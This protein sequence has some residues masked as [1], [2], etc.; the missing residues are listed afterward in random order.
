MQSAV[1]AA[2]FAFDDSFETAT[3]HGVG[4]EIPANR[5]FIEEDASGV[6]AVCY[7]EFG[8]VKHAHAPQQLRISIRK[9]LSLTT[10]G[11]RRLSRTEKYKYQIYFA[12]K[13]GKHERA[14][15]IRFDSGDDAYGFP[16]V[17]HMHIQVD[18]V[19]QHSVRPHPVHIGEGFPHLSD[20]FDIALG[21]AFSDIGPV[22]YFEGLLARFKR[23]AHPERAIPALWVPKLEDRLFSFLLP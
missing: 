19:P 15:L 10:Q 22:T 5:L 11:A 16:S 4:Q 12:D 9:R 23:I 18:S 17:H 13:K 1:Q 14:S 20:I 2:S 7:G 6:E 21:M 8:L 3:L